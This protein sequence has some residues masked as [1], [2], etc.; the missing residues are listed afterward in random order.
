MCGRYYLKT[1]PAQL[2]AQFGLD[3]IDIPGEPRENIAPT[4]IVPVVLNEAPTVLQTVK[5]GLIP[6]WSKDGK[7]GGRL[8]N[9]RADGIDEKPIFRAAF[10][11][12]RCLVLADGFY[13]WKKVDGKKIPYRISLK[14]GGPI[15]F[16][17]LWEVWKPPTGGDKIK[18]C[19]IITTDANALIR[20]LHDRMPVILPYGSESEWLD[21][22]ENPSLALSLLR[23]YPED[24][25]IV[26]EF[27]PERL[28]IRR[29][30]KAAAG[31][32]P[33]A[34]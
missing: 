9:A 22:D 18:S 27:D 13:E 34:D 12:R 3:K 31:T 17:G 30:D 14:S 2:A 8:I 29:G 25:L 15:A 26:E 6:F 33:F 28:K 20:D 11:K 10:K 7:E 16:A 21:I 32:L 5:W 4:E 23:P 24:E 1:P 19:T